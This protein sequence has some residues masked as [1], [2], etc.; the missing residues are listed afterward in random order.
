MMFSFPDHIQ[1]SGPRRHSHWLGM[2]GAVIA[3]GTL[4]AAALWFS[5]PH[6][7]TLIPPEPLPLSVRF[8]TP[9]PPEPVRR[10]EPPPPIPVPHPQP[11]V[12]AAP[13]IITKPNPVPAAAV[14]IAA[15]PVAAAP[16]IPVAA[17]PSMPVAETA[18]AAAPLVEARF[19]AAYLNNPRPIY[20]PASRRKG[21]TGTVFLRVHVAEDG[22]ALEVVLKQSSGSERLDQSALET[23]PKWTFVPAKRGDKAEKAWVVVPIIFTL[24]E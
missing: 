1:P 6:S 16:S 24:D 2:G 15:E 18:P 17:P 10:Q 9:P 12:K 23:V 21:E 4:L 20:P 11:V 22:H 7:S 14:S 19:D 5:L 8:I 3:H 13:H